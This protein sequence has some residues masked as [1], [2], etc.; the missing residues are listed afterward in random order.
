MMETKKF[1]C[2]GCGSCCNKILINYVNKPLNIIA[3]LCLRPDEVELFASHKTKIFPYIAL[4]RDNWSEPKIIMYQMIVEPCP[5]LNIEK[6]I[7][8][9]YKTRPNICRMYPFSIEEKGLSI[10]KTCTYSKENINKSSFGNIKITYPKDVHHALLNHHNKFIGI[11][12]KL[13]SDKKLN[14]LIFDFENNVWV[15]RV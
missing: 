10:E 13:R 3:G 11:E 1:E 6:N 9:I 5:H 7:C 12:N 4:Q 8:T 15:K 2:S 14:L